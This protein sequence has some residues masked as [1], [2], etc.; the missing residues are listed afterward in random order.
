MAVVEMEPGF[1]VVRVAERSYAGRRPFDDK[2][3]AEIRRKIQ[4]KV[5]EREFR[6]VVDGLKA[7]VPVTILDAAGP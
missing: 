7:T 5:S 2:T 6:R 4:A 1:H 3:Q